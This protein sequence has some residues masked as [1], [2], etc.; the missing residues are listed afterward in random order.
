MPNPNTPHIECRLAHPRILTRDELRALDHDAARSLGLP[1]LLLMENAAIGAADV[2][3]ERL[4]R[5]PNPRPVLIIAGPGNNGGDGIAL[6]RHL[7]I[8]GIDAALLLTSEDLAPDA[9]TNL[10]ALRATATPIHAG[11][12]APED[13]ARR[14]IE[15]LSPSI[16]IDALL[17]TGLT[18]PVQ[19][20]LAGVI[21]AINTARLG[22]PGTAVVAL[23]L[24]TGLDAD[25]GQP[26]GHPDHPTIRADLTVTFAALK[27][28]MFTIE[29]Q[30]YLGDVTLVPIGV[31][32]EFVAGYGTPYEPN[33][34]NHARD[35]HPKTHP[36]G[37]PA[38]PGRNESTQP[39]F[40]N[41]PPAGP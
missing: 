14:L 10:G 29:A 3:A 6:A 12:G 20:P 41:R 15:R 37:D 18:R 4:G 22:S 8:R 30:P 17:G 16:I 26:L 21:G 33:P 27:T 35:H 2:V 1:P 25:T 24:P 34:S 19:G 32:H 36:H 38:A 9:A 39:Q 13:T 28:G 7:W 11:D 31:P 23:D 40:P 5:T